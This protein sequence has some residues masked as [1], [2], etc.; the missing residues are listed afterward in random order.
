[1]LALEGNIPIP[2]PKH[3]QV[4]VAGSYSPHF[5][6]A[7][8]FSFFPTMNVVLE[9]VGKTIR[10]FRTILDFGCGCGRAT[11]A[12]ARLHPDAELHG[13][14][15]DPEAIAWMNLHYAAFGSFSVAPHEPPLPYADN[16]FDFIFG[17]S[18][19]THLPEVMQFSWLAE[20]ARVTQ[21]GGYL[22]LTTHGP[23][24]WQNLSSEI[25]EI[26]DTKGFLFSDFG[27]NYG[28][29]IN[30]PDFYQTSFH[31]HEYINREWSRYFE[32]VQITERGID[33]HQDAVLLRKRL[34]ES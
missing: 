28:K 31:A 34:A 14:D 23:K 29:S 18:V 26:M 27:T 13:T 21:P 4:R 3:L 2:P 11:R 22:I 5:I 30:L 15:I 16:F 9:P 6:Y 1:M 32:V 25:R 24:H 8:Y 7:G 17:I 12:L 10:D 20:L 33:G 19:F